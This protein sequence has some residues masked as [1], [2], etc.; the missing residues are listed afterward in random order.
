[1]FFTDSCGYFAMTSK[2]RQVSSPLSRHNEAPLAT[3]QCGKYF[4]HKGA[5]T[6]EYA[7]HNKI[8]KCKIRKHCCDMFGNTIM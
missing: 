4:T 1:M 3:L 6:L 7:S 5:Y 2:D 8:K